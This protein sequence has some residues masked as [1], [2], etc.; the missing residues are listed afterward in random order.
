M[1]KNKHVEGSDEF[2][3][4]SDPMRSDGGRKSGGEEW[5]LERLLDLR[6]AHSGRH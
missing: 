6:P 5:N 1:F 3:D 4:E 2:T